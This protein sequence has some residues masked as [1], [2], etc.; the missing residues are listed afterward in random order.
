MASFQGLGVFFHNN[1]EAKVQKSYAQALSLCIVIQRDMHVTSLGFC[2]RVI[3]YEKP[4]NLEKTTSKVLSLLVLINGC[5]HSTDLTVR[6]A[7]NHTKGLTDR[8]AI[9][10]K[11][12]TLEFQ[13]YQRFNE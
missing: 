4:Q 2:L 6:I 7:S 5:N 11:R 9:I 10:P 1:P 13:R 8:I 12:L 3:V